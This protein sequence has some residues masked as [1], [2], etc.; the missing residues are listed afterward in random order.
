M[1]SVP[2]PDRYVY[3]PSIPGGRNDYCTLSPD[4]FPAPGDNADFSGAC[5]RHDLCYDRADELGLQYGSCN[6]RFGD[7]LSRVCKENY[8][9]E[10]DPR[11]R[12]CILTAR[13]IYQAAVQFKHIGENRDDDVPMD[14]I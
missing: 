3:D 10:L 8:T 11:R 6:D 1:G 12:S 4:Q 5:A 14:Y 2:V 13:G 9:S 7:D